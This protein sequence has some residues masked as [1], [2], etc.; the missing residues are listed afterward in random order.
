MIFGSY[1]TLFFFLVEQDLDVAK[2]KSF[3]EAVHCY[4]G[5]CLEPLD[6]AIGDFL[7]QGFY[8]IGGCEFSERWA[9]SF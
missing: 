2:G 8:A 7:V 6:R 1:A 9:N 4:C 3:Y 5:Q